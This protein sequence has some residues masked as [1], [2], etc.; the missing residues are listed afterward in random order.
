MLGLLVEL[1]CVLLGPLHRVAR[2]ASERECPPVRRL[3][4]L[5]AL[6][7][8]PHE[9]REPAVA[10]LPADRLDDARVRDRLARRRPLGRHVQIRRAVAR[11]RVAST[12][13]H[14]A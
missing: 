8:P 10:L 7:A 4:L 5:P 14:W 2:L 11:H 6:G 12:V 13:A 3:L 1:T 9:T